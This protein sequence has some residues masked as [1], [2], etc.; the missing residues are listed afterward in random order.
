[1]INTEII[2]AEKNDIRN[3]LIVG[4]TGSGKSSLANV[5][6]DT[7]TN[8]FEEGNFSISVTKNFQKGDV[9]QWNEKKYRVVDNIGFSDTSNLSEEYVLY[10]IGEGI[11]SAKEGINQVFFVFKGRFS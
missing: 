4:L 11:Y 1:M 6:T 2:A 9:F 5:L 3:A 7:G 8:Q 10:E